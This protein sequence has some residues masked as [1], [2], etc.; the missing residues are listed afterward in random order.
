MEPPPPTPSPL[1]LSVYFLPPSLHLLLLHHLSPCCLSLLQLESYLFSCLQEGILAL[2]P[3]LALPPLSTSLSLSGSTPPPLYPTSP[4]PTCS[5][6]CVASIYGFIT[7]AIQGRRRGARWKK[8]GM[9]RDNR[10]R[11]TLGNEGGVRVR[12]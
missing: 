10:G 4:K 1:P 9:E 7:A 8:R 5:H 12:E 11:E 2:L 3:P 6:R